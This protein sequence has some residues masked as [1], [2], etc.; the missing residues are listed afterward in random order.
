MRLV[1]MWRAKRKRNGNFGS[2]SKEKNLEIFTVW[3]LADLA[4]YHGIEIA[5]SNSE[6]SKDDKLAARVRL[7]FLMFVFCTSIQCSTSDK[8]GQPSS[9]V[10]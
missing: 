8:Y 5:D 3:T 6:E 4:Q 7:R 1:C 9:R 10:L 2:T